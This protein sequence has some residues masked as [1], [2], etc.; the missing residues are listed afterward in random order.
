MQYLCKFTLQKSSRGR[1]GVP[2]SLFAPG[3]KKANFGLALY[4]E[5]LSY[6]VIEFFLLFV[7]SVTGDVRYLRFLCL[8]RFL[9]KENTML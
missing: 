2:K 4:S 7:I 8:L 1:E 6:I 5:K 9:D 3:A